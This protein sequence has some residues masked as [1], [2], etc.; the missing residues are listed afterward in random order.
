MAGVPYHA[1]EQYLARL[2]KLGES[3]AI[4]EQ[5]GDP[6]TSKGPVERKV[7]RV[8]TPGTL[9][10]ATLLDAQARQPAR[11]RE[12]GPAPQRASR[13]SNLASGSF[14]LAEVPRG[15]DRGGARAARRR[16]AAGPRRRDVAA[17]ARRGRA[18]ARAAGLALR[19]RRPPTRALAQHFGTRDLAAFGAE[20]R[21]LAVGAAG[22]LLDYAAAT[23][24]AALAHVRTLAVEAPSDYLQLDAGDAAQ[25]RDHRDAARRAAR[26]RCLSLLDALRH[27]PPAAG[28]CATG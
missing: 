13:G 7:L 12:S 19:R 21:D 17:A 23:Q 22:A 27:A 4:C 1:V 8:V 15:R 16:R 14:T 2:M 5:I 10:D 6:A 3:V 18:D 9:T 24:A 26:R 11:R 28:C 20:D 25:S